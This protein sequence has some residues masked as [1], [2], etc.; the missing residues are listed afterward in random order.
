[1][2]AFLQRPDLDP[3]LRL[4]VLEALDGLA[5]TVRVRQRYAGG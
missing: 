4:K 5:R 3:D 2:R 1:V